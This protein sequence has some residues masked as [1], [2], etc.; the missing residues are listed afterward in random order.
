MAFS[1]C[2]RRTDHVLREASKAVCH[3]PDVTHVPEPWPHPRAVPHGPE[4]DSQ[5]TRLLAH[6]GQCGRAVFLW[7]A[8]VGT[9]KLADPVG[10]G[11]L[12]EVFVGRLSHGYRPALS[13]RNTKLQHF[14]LHFTQYS[15]S[16]TSD[17][18]MC[19]ISP[20]P[21]NSPVLSRHQR[22]APQM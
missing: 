22:G 6:P 20:T 16:E 8:S 17:R 7:P 14:P 19:G 13:R 2:P 18:Q 12:A 11:L 3:G 5:D 21:N 10:T 4:S 15:T 9:D 1:A